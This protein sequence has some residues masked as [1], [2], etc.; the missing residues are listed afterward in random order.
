MRWVVIALHRPPG[1]PVQSDINPRAS[2]PNNADTPQKSIRGQWSAIVK[3][4]QSPGARHCSSQFSA[5][6]NLADK[7]VSG[8]SGTSCRQS[9][10]Q[11]VPR[12]Q[13][14]YGEFVP[15]TSLWCPPIGSVFGFMP[16]LLVY[17]LCPAWGTVQRQ[18]RD[19]PYLS[20]LRCR[21]RNHLAECCCAGQE[22]P[23]A[24][25]KWNGSNN[26]IRAQCGNG[27]PDTGR[28]FGAGGFRYALGYRIS[29]RS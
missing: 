15:D 14:Q 22:C 24:R 20:G 29:R 26:E 17:C 11:A 8:I 12:H 1:R 13:S 7:L 21:L 6:A 25:L 5:I 19:S 23:N 18:R 28:L 3:I 16:P 4:A 10:C 9:E 27:L 2:F